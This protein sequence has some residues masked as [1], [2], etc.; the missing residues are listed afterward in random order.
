MSVSRRDLLKRSAA[1]GGVIW[2]APLVKTTAAWALPG[3]CGEG[4]DQCGDGTPVYAKFAPGN[5]Q[6][7]TNQCLAPPIGV[8]SV[9]FDCL[10]AAN[11]VTKDTVTTS[12]DQAALRFDPGRV[13]I[14]RLAIKSDNSAFAGNFGQEVDKGGCLM[15][16]CVEGFKRVWNFEP[17]DN[18]PPNQELKNSDI[19]TTPNPPV[20][21]YTLA[22]DSVTDTS[23]LSPTVCDP[24][25]RIFFDT[26]GL[27][28][29]GG[30]H[31]LNF[32][33]MLLCIQNA[34]TIPCIANAT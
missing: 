16:T 33:E 3:Y 20:F 1:A 29:G 25:K 28:V 17:K 15:V 6:P 18:P 2:A 22:D 21:K 13:K 27:A 26:K 30:R 8:K 19:N 23:T 32:I 10:S 14:L 12:Q 4:C 24:V 31:K 11:L 9:S 34:S 5:A 7:T